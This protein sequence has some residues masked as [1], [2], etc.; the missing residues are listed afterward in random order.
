M[1]ILPFDTNF[2]SRCTY[3]AD[4]VA[5]FFRILQYTAEMIRM[6]PYQQNLELIEP[7]KGGLSVSIVRDM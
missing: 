1:A 5:S 2:D 7:S 3:M 6:F 4:R